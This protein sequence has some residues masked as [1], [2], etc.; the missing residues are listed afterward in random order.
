M[1][2]TSKGEKPLVNMLHCLYNLLCKTLF[3]SNNWLHEV[4]Y[5]R[6]TNVSSFTYQKLFHEKMKSFGIKRFHTN[7][8]NSLI[9]S[10]KMQTRKH[11]K[12]QPDQ[13]WQQQQQ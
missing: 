1:K 6:C 13:P 5:F 3:T 12:Q 9:V 11:Y 7:N 8:R 10:I 2:S 4:Y